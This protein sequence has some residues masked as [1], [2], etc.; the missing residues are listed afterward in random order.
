[1]KLSD[2]VVSFLAEKGITDIFGYPGG[3]V[4]HLMDS[5]KKYE[6]VIHAHVNYHEQASAFSACGYAQVTGLPGVAYAT[7]G[8]GASNLITGVANA[9]FDSIPTLFLTGQVNTYE[10]KGNLSVR[11]KGFQEMDVIRMVSSVTKYAA[12]VTDPLDIRYELEKAFYLCTTGR[13]GPVLLDLPMNIQRQD[14]DVSSLRAFVPDKP[15]APNIAADAIADMVNASSRPCIVVGAGVKTA[16]MTQAFRNLVSSL[17]IPVVSSMIA[18]D[19]LPSDDAN[20]YGFIGAYGARKANFILA[21]SDLIL[22]F[23]SRL[24]LRQIGANTETFAPTAKLV[25]FDVDEGEL[26]SRIKADELQVRADMKAVIPCLCDSIRLKK[27]FSAW[28]KVCDEIADK[29]TGIDDALPNTLMREMSRFVPDNTVITTDVGQNQVWAAQSFLVKEKQQILFSGGLG[30][31]G[32]S[33]PAAIG[34]YYGT[35]KNV[36]SI[37][38]DGGMQMNIQEL[39]FI[40]REQL[41]IKIVVF[42]N[43]ALGM[44]RHF[45]EMYFDSRYIQTVRKEGYCAPSFQKL[46][47]AYDMEYRCVTKAADFDSALFAGDSPIIIEVLLDGNT[48]VSP[49]LAMQKPNQDQE[50]P[51][52]RALYDYLMAL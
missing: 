25:R 46:A 10:S 37:N 6:E 19:A 43:Q 52:D 20:N 4:T 17:N 21:K 45:Q 38:G 15:P 5:L 18:V 26:T 11:Q 28:R 34:A 31:M 51:I 29:L 32:Y 3:M 1:M 39:Q 24:D 33:L 22:A 16:G 42:N 30:A 47:A 49:K 36:V 50:P 35:K 40:K 23:G 9:Y 48:Y 8:P 27:D 41:P 44:I 12:L 14:I 13:P 2:Y 7:S